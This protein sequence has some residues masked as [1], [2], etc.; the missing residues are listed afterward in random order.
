[1]ELNCSAKKLRTHESRDS[2]ALVFVVPRSLP[3]SP[4]QSGGRVELAVRLSKR[5]RGDLLWIAVYDCAK[6]CGKR[7]TQKIEGTGTL[8]F[9]RPRSIV[10]RSF[11]SSPAQSEWRVS[12]SLGV[13]KRPGADL[14][15]IPVDECG[16]DRTSCS[17]VRGLGFFSEGSRSPA[18][19]KASLLEGRCGNS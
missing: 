10:P 13:G 14:L 9:L 19:G 5:G 16:K 15:W 11:W 12:L 17:D 18:G 3:G 7:G 2:C 4:A 6:A 1:M 8:R